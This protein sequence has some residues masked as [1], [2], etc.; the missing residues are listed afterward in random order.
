MKIL[1]LG[2]DGQVGSELK[3]LLEPAAEL[4]AP[5]LDQVDL[6]RP[7]Q[8]RD[9]VRTVRPQ[10]ILNAAAYTAVDAA[11][12][13]EA[14]AATLNVEAPA[15][16]AAEA[17]KLGALLV[18]Y[19]TDYVFDG[20][21]RTPYREGDPPNPMSAYGRSKLAGEHAIQ[22]S[23]CRH[24]ILRTAW[25]YASRGKNFVLTMLRLAKER[26]ELRVVADQIGSPTWARSLAEA[27]VQMVNV[28]E[29]GV[30]SIFPANNGS[31]P[32]FPGVY[33]VTG[34][35]HCSWQ[36]FAERIVER[37]AAL[38]LC[39]KVPVKAITTAEYPTPATRPTYSVLSN[40][41]L[42]A[43]FG[44]RLPAWEDA[45]DDCLGEVRR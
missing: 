18:H 19:S 38:G 3:R 29:K 11:E 2:R 39:R 23:G 31:D 33:H 40:E 25:V 14:L 17:A 7:R 13:E 26:D 22:A 35:G 6:T 12:K 34:S 42:A 24:L 27:T 37:G 16:L 41:K 8:I 43:D 10:V 5:T 21:K 45:L 20:A 28:L 30:R 15:L 32:F 4:T 1:L 9:A 44:I 36:A